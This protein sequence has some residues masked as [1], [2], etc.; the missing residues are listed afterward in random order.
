MKQYR[1][2]IGRYCRDPVI[3]K[4]TAGEM[5]CYLVPLLYIAWLVCHTLNLPSLCEFEC[6]RVVSDSNVNRFGCLK[7]SI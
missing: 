2:V 3:L 7:S 6:E 1:L 5:S 4:E